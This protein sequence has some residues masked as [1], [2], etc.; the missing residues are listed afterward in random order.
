MI[1]DSLAHR[2]QYDGLVEG[3]LA[4]AL[5]FLA[6]TDFS[7][8]ADGRYEI[9]GDDV[10]ANVGSYTT[11]AAN[12]TPEAHKKYMDVQYVFEG[13]EII[14]VGPL[15]EMGEEVSAHPENDI[16]NYQAGHL[17]F[18]TLEKGRFVAVWPKD[19]HAPGVAVGDPAPA[20]KCVVKVRV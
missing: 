17:D 7:T 16:W 13:R 20:R 15:E 2:A 5:A 10:F 4:K 12:T 19:A 11:K 14:G 1:Y 3:R 6:E 18:V 9:D 8:L